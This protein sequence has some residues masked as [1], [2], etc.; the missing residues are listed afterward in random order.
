MNQKIIIFAAMLNQLQEGTGLTVKSRSGAYGSSRLVIVDVKGEE[1][2]YEE[3]LE[4]GRGLNYV[5][6]NESKSRS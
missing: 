6:T 2:D 1:H 5:P 3:A 4:A